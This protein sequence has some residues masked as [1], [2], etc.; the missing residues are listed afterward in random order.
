MY[1]D[2]LLRL[3][4]PLLAATRARKIKWS[5][6]ADEDTFLTAFKD[7]LIRVSQP[8]SDDGTTYRVALLNGNNTL[9]EEMTPTNNA[10]EQ[11]L[12]EL[13]EAARHSALQVDDVFKS[14]EA[15]LDKRMRGQPVG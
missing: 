3:L 11:L 10:E 12:R 6:S 2:N 13:F 9:V 15:E 5:E 1:R 4:G 8:S 14:I 7:G